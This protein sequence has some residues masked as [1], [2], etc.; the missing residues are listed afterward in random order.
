MPSW[1]GSP[2]AEEHDGQ[3]RRGPLGGQHA[4]R[5]PAGDDDVDLERD[6]LR[7]QRGEPLGPALG[8]PILD[9]HGAALDVAKVPQPLEER[10]SRAGIRAL[11]IERQVADAGNL[12]GL[13][14]LDAERRGEQPESAE[15]GAPV[16]YSIT[17][18]ARWSSDGG[19]VS[20]S[21][22]AVLRLM[23]SSNFVGCSI[24]RSAGRAP[25]RILST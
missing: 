11:H 22:L 6:Q 23:R 10:L 7:R 13:L 16:H 4:E 15:E 1:T 17:R 8:V 20:P 2:T 24:G 21:A 12:P 19:I 18:S 5:A 9:Q 25:L 14:R 3:R